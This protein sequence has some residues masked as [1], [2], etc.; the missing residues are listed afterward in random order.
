MLESLLG[1]PYRSSND[2]EIITV[3]LIALGI[4]AVVWI[5]FGW[6]LYRVGKRRGYPHSWLAWV[7]LGNVWMIV[8]ISE[9][10]NPAA[11]FSALILMS[12][13]P[14]LISNIDS[15]PL[16]LAVSLITSMV[17]I[18]I[19]VLLWSA[20]AELRGK[21]GWWGILWIV[22]VAN[23]VI[24]VLLGNK[25]EASQYAQGYYYA[26]GYP[27]QPYQMQGVYYPQA[28]PVQAN[29]AG[30]DPQQSYPPQG[31]PQQYGQPQYPQQ[32]PEQPSP[33][34]LY[35]EGPVPSGDPVNGTDDKPP[36]PRSS[37]L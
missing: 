9:K 31:Y 32:Y 24:L 13:A 1:A 12:L 4:I 20:I 17:S 37:W 30:A 21:P 10:K 8:D 5:V 16:H 29:P 36:A 33:G 18:V 3:I 11:W 19:Y 22:P 14:R 23:I 35:P 25:D 27:G 2:T 15:R 26:P 34:Q 6:L 28:Y 7:P